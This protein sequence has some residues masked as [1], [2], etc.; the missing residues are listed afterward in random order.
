[1]QMVVHTSGQ[2]FRGRGHSLGETRR[3]TCVLRGRIRCCRVLCLSNVSRT[4]FHGACME[5]SVLCPP[6]FSFLCEE[7]K[8]LATAPNPVILSPPVYAHELSKF[9]CKLIEERHLEWL[10]LGRTCLSVDSERMWWVET[11]YGGFKVGGDTS[12]REGVCVWVV[13]SFTIAQAVDVSKQEMTTNLQIHVHICLLHV[14]A[15][16]NHLAPRRSHSLL[17]TYSLQLRRACKASSA[18]LGIRYR[19]CTA[20]ASARGWGGCRQGLGARQAPSG[21]VADCGS[22]LMLTGESNSNSIFLK[23]DD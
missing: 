21:L 16:S 9:V 18:A 23:S 20:C 13:P 14:R 17:D 19:C 7:A 10:R 1:M 4:A 12:C 8:E 22:L 15:S 2:R 5:R 3:R 6:S 11:W